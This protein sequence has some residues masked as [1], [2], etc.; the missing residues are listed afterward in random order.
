MTDDERCLLEKYRELKVY[1]WGELRVTITKSSGKPR[2]TIFVTKSF[3]PT[4]DNYIED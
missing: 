2:A 4:I 3:K 1:G